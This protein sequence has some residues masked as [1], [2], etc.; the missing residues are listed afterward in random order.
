VSSEISGERLRLP[1]S[2]RIAMT[3][4]EEKVNRKM[5]E[6]FMQVLKNRDLSRA[7]DLFSVPDAVI[8]NDLTNVVS[9]KKLYV[10]QL[11][12]IL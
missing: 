6:L 1:T 7:G 11:S 12:E 5:H 10:A 4:N 3:T 8:V 9:K 2:S